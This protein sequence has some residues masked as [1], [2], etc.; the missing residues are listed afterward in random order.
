MSSSCFQDRLNQ[1]YIAA[2]CPFAA[3]KLN[4]NSEGYFCK[5]CSKTIVDFRDKTTEEI[6][7]VLKQ[8]K[9]CGVFL[10][11][12]LEVQPK[13]NF[14]SSLKFQFLLLASI[15]GFSIKPI[16][17]QINNTVIDTS[18]KIKTEKVSKV[19]DQTQKKK[20][21]KRQQ[22]KRVKRD[23]LLRRNRIVIGCPEF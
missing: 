22:K 19:K 14:R 7:E 11:E 13:L 4:K 20:E 10:N 16:K 3:S 17:S 23:L 9:V 2:P 21:S 12:Q 18:D 15:L 6:F 5:S 1:L 8:N